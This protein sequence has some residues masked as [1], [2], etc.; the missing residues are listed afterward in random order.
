M[1]VYLRRLV[2]IGLL[3]CWPL[4]SLAAMAKISSARIS[5]QPHKTRLVLVSDK[6]VKYR[7][8]AL[9]K[10][11]RVV[12]DIQNASLQTNLKHLSLS[13]TPI[14]SIRT[15]KRPNHHLRIVIDVK[16][17][18]HPSAF[19]LAPEMNY[20]DRLVLDLEPVKSHRHVV[21]HNSRPTVVKS[22]L[23]L[24]SAGRRDIIV[25]IDPGHGGK[26]P[27]ASGP[28][29]THEKRVV[30]DIS[31]DLYHLLKKQPG[32]K[33]VMT[34][35]SDQ[36]ISLRTRLRIARKDKADM[37]VAI[38][39]DAYKNRSAHGASVY[40]LSQR[41]AS[42]EAAR[43]LAEKE[44]Y[45]EL[46]GVDLN[47]LQD[48]GQMLR[49]VL[50]DLSQTATIAQSVEIG[51]SVLGQLSRVGKLHHN[52]VE[53]ARFVVLKSPD[54]PSILV[55][56]GFIS[57]PREERNLDNPK[58]RIK[59]AKAIFAGIKNYFMKNPPRGTLF[60]AM[61]EQGVTNYALL[62]PVKSPASKAHT[63]THKPKHVSTA[64]ANS[65]KKAAA[66][67]QQLSHKKKVKTKTKAKSKPKLQRYKVARGDS[68]SIIA[69]RQ[70]TSIRSLRKLNHLY[71]NNIYVG[72]IL[73]VPA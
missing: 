48:Q 66:K 67:K 18:M 36:Y 40:A 25:V 32:M 53:Q 54:I 38:H 33:P 12:L 14:K 72:Q 1:T 22:A 57:N 42:S 71:S 26:D 47:S 68:L 58:Y 31:R 6:P 43:W 35:N 56:T 7:V 21:T 69:E 63:S 24:K 39:A 3:L 46:G 17:A 49:S 29:G 41:G 2:I 51:N 30:L 70:H 64:K 10:P 62:K 50:I 60:A 4:L 65:S 59:L 52:K 20:R 5:S 44:N 73:K 16:Q 34:R 13:K 19:L 37:F 55:E 28:R 45:S 61:K 23:P 11:Q 8:F 9:N 27:G 15:A